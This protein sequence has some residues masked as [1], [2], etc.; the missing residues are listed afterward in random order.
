LAFYRPSFLSPESIAISGSQNNDF[1]CQVNV[2]GETVVDY[3]LKILTMA[4]VSVYDT[5]TATPTT[6]LYDKDR[7]YHTVP[8]GT[9]TNG[10][11][12]KWIMTTNPSSATPV[13]SKETPFWAYSYPTVVF[14]STPTTIT[15][16]SYNFTCTYT[17]A[18]SVPFAKW[19]MVWYDVA[20]TIIEDSGWSYSGN[21]SYTFDGFLDTESYKVKCFVE[22]QLG[23]L[24]DTGYYQFLVD[25]ASPNLNIVPDAILIPEVGAVDVRW[26]RAVQITGSYTGATPTYISNFMVTGNNALS[27]AS[28][29]DTVYFDNLAIPTGST[30][31]FVWQN[32]VTPLEINTSHTFSTTSE[33]L[34]FSQDLG[35]VFPVAQ[36]DTDYL[37]G[38]TYAE[39]INVRFEVSLNGSSWSAFSTAQNLD[40]TGWS[41]VPP[42]Q[43]YPYVTYTG[44]PTTARYIRAYGTPVF[45]LSYIDFMNLV[46]YDPAQPFS[47][48]ICSLDNGAYV[49]SY[50]GTKFVLSGTSFPSNLYSLPVV[51]PLFPC[52]VVLFS[53]KAYIIYNNALIASVEI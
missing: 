39:G 16:K 34:I 12:Y 15:A 25:Y 43:P 53:T 5:G 37:T 28:A 17:Q 22:S 2:S 3:R 1:S 9:L 40:S 27:L 21:I 44:T 46:A 19:K 26:G 10:N 48:T 47:G 20:N 24:I 45:A 52:L 18:Q 50:D 7:L 29:S 11:Q 49:L 30:I 23:T 31:K 42:P 32:G 38:G 33:E 41:P 8:S 13:Y 4:N 6:N 51:L 14:N 36:I 35:S